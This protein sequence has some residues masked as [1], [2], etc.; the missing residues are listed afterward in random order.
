MYL[1]ATEEVLWQKLPASLREGWEVTEEAH[2]AYERP[3]ELRMRAH[4]ASFQK[5]PAVQ[6]LTQKLAGGA[7]V[8]EVSLDDIPEDVLPDVYFTMGAAGVKTLIG[9]LLPRIQ[10]DQDV[11]G[12][13]SLTE[14]RHELLAA[15]AA[16]SYTTA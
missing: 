2:I 3:E 5:H 12:L 8:E 10:T 13:A 4:I 16:I 1:T 11:E 15:N 14:V 9:A 7:S 6:A